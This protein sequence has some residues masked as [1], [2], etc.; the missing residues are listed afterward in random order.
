MQTHVTFSQ[1]GDLLVTEQRI[2]S[3][4]GQEAFPVAPALDNRGWILV[5]SD[6]E[7]SGL[8]LLGSGL[9]AS[10]MADIPF[11]NE[12]SKCLVIPHIAQDGLWDTTILICN[13]NDEA[14][15]IALKYVDQ[16]GV[17]QGS[18]NYTIPA[19]GSGEY[20][21]ST[22]FSDKIP[23][24]GRIEINSSTGIATFALYSNRKSGGTY[25]AGINAGSCE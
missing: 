1:E 14:A 13:P 17:E 2:V 16:L 23:L 3:A 21:L 25:Y 12:L 24:A 6:Q 19:Y 11:A 22:N 4:Y 15:S 9:E 10:L 20:P 5:N 8:A 7:M 18:K